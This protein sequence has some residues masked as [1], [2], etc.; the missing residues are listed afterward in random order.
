MYSAILSVNPSGQQ[1]KTVPDQ[2]EINVYAEIIC[3]VQH[4]MAFTQITID[5]YIYQKQYTDPNTA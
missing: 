4:R 1:R 3:Y 2:N 5:F